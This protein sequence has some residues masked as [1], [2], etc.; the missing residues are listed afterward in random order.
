MLMLILRNYADFLI[1]LCI[2][3]QYKYVL[4][5]TNLKMRL[6]GHALGAPPIANIIPFIALSRNLHNVGLISLRFGHWI[7]FSPSLLWY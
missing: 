3:S 2:V 7:C 4:M 1:A 5:Y 6:L